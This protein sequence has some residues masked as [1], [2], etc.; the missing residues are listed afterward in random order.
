MYYIHTLKQ[1][2]GSAKTYDH[3]SLNERS[4]VDRY[5][6]HIGAKLGLSVDKNHD[7]LP[8]PN[9]LLKLHNKRP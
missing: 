6:C 7:N 3:N 8:M 4:V 9:C 2:L 1:E 5:T